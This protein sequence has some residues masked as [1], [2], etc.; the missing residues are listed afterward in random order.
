MHALQTDGVWIGAS[1]L[2]TGAG[3]SIK[4]VAPDG[5]LLRR[6]LASIRRI[7]TAVAPR[8]ACDA[9]KL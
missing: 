9:R 1:Q 5:I 3:W 7:L 4:F 8:L 2:R 6:T